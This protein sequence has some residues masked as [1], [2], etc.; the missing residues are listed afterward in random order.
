MTSKDLIKTLEVL[1]S[2]GRDAVESMRN[3]LVTSGKDATGNLINSL[4]YQVS[5]DGDD[6]TLEFSMAEHGKFV[7]SGR[8]PNS[9]PPPVSALTPWLAI[10][11][12]PQSA[13]FAV[14]RSIGKKGIPPVPF[15][16]TSVESG[17]EKLIAD[18]EI[19]FAQ[20]LEAYITKKSSR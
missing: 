3:I 4:S 13:G 19:A 12:I 17:R 14:A 11:G 16:E 2:Y 1:E 9:L 7:E 15:F 10:R 20:D 18:L 6:L 8:K 5:V